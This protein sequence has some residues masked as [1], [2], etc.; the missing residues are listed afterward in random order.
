MKTLAKNES[1]RIIDAPSFDIYTKQKL[2]RRANMPT[3]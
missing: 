2:I 3:K 1:F